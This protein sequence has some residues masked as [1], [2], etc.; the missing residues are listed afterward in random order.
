MPRNDINHVLCWIHPG[1]T[2]STISGK[3]V[4]KRL[5]FFTYIP[6]I[7]HFTTFGEQEKRVELIKKLRGRLVNCDQNS[8]PNCSQFAK[9]PH[10]IVGGL[11]I[12]ARRRLIEKDQDAWFRDELHTNRDSLALLYGKTGSDLT[13]ES[14][15]EVV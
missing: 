3:V 14:I 8:L 1:R 12:Q 9:K 4:L 2:W 13:D 10:C 6:K 15:T 7:H 5:G 11:A